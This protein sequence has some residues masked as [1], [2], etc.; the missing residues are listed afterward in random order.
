MPE[1]EMDGHLGYEK[2]ERS[3]QSN[4]CN[5]HRSKKVRGDQ[6]DLE[7]QVLRDRDGKFNPVLIDWKNS[8]LDSV[9]LIVWIDGIIFKIRENSKVVNKTSYLAVGLNW[10][11]Y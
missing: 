3:D 5:G 4:I 2:H 6:G 1:G 11:G 7:I 10:D 9:Y 8:P